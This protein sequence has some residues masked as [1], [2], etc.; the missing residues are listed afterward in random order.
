M[1]NNIISYKMKL[2]YQS[3]YI[4]IGILRKFPIP[5]KNSYFRIRFPGNCNKPEPVGKSR[6]AK[7]RKRGEVRKYCIYYK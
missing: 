1:L 7:C 2:N 4:R 6:K 5:L 3:K